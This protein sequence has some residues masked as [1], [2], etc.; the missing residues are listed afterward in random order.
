MQIFCK[1]KKKE[2]G[3]EFQL[4]FYTFFCMGSHTHDKMY[5]FEFFFQTSIFSPNGRLF[6]SAFSACF[7]APPWAYISS[8]YVYI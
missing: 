6:R 1:K 7:Y 4:C 5:A 3:T 8:I 2:G